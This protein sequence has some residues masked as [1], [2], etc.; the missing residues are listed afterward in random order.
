MKKRE[1][2][3][4]DLTPL[5]DV[6][7]ILLIFFILTASFKKDKFTLSLEL[8]NSSSKQKAVQEKQ[9]SLELNKTQLV[10]NSIIISFDD[11]KTELKIIK[12]KE[13][14]IIINIDKE[15]PYQRVI[16]LLDLL[17]NNN[18][19]NIAFVTSDS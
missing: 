18:L 14:A 3:S 15:V 1:Y 16:K 10:Y 8:P 12:D 9:V 5:I 11:L 6:V 13:Q 7:F 2:L 19:N 17:Q 4:P